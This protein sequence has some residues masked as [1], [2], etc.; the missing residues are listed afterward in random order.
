MRHYLAILGVI[1]LLLP[2]GCGDSEPEQ[3]AETGPE[4]M[5]EVQVGPLSAVPGDA[6]VFATVKSPQGIIDKFKELMPDLEELEEPLK[7]PLAPIRE[8]LGDVD[9]AGPAAV[10]V[11]DMEN[12][13]EDEPPIVFVLSAAD[14]EAVVASH[15]EKRAGGTENTERMNVILSADPGGIASAFR[16]AEE[17]RKKN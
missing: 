17:S 4:P 10:I 8:V 1:C 16:M 11:T 2:A 9:L 12:L 6:C 7:D 14:A 15:R 3:K 13:E 5:P